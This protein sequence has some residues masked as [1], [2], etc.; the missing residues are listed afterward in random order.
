MTKGCSFTESALDHHL[1]SE[2]LEWH[3]L[4]PFPSFFSLGH[5]KTCQSIPPNNFAMKKHEASSEKR[6]QQAG[7][8]SNPFPMRKTGGYA[9]EQAPLEEGG[10]DL[11]KRDRMAHTAPTGTQEGEAAGLTYT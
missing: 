11:R 2:G 7:A 1:K 10:G 3:F 6:K 9:G 4:F 8:D 5:I